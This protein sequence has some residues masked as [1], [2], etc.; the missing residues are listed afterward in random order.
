[1]SGWSFTASGAASVAE[2]VLRITNELRTVLGHEEAGTEHITTSGTAGGW[3][4]EASGDSDDPNVH[5]ALAAELGRVISDPAAE[6]GHSTFTSAH[7]QLANFHDPAPLAEDGASALSGPATPG[8]R[9]SAAK[10]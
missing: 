5:K 2:D 9:S 4:A 1:M 10:S 7:V 3:A 6:T 8:R